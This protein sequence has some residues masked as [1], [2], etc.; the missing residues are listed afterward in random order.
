MIHKEINGCFFVGILNFIIFVTYQLYT[1]VFRDGYGRSR[2]VRGHRPFCDLVVQL[3]NSGAF[4][5]K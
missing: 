3:F 2:A 1:R 5:A 4:C